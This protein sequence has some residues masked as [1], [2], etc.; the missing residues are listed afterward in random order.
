LIFLH[1]VKDLL[2]CL[3]WQSWCAFRIASQRWWQPF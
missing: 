2:E 1:S 3:S